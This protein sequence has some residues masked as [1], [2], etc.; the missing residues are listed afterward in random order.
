[1]NG[2]KV[3][4]LIGLPGAGKDLLADLFVK[5]NN[6]NKIAFADQIKKEYYEFSGFNEKMFK[7][8]RKTDLELK[9]REGLWKYSDKMKKEFGDLHFITPV[10]QEI[11][12]SKNPIFVTDVRTLDEIK[13]LQKIDAQLICIVRELA[14][15]NSKNIVPGTRLEFKDIFG[16]PVFWN[17]SNSVDVIYSDFIMFCKKALNIGWLND[18]Y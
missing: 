8:N 5:H 13:E 6:F 4:G 2:N 10:I 15:N 12:K 11:K 14:R 17:Y 16:I 18:K 9:I 7:S 3:L 1:M